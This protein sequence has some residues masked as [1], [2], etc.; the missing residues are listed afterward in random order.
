MEPFIVVLGIA[1][2]LGL[3]VLI[4]LIATFN[5]FVRLRQHMKESWS[6]IDVELKRRHD[7]IPNLVE[8]V[9]GYAAHEREV[10]EK[11]ILL[12]NQAA[13]SHES[14]AA[15][16]GDESAL[17]A[18]L[19]RLFALAENYPVLKADQNFLALQRE[20][21]LTE[22]RIAAARRFF[23]ANVRDNNR[24]C[25][26]FPTNILAGMFGF[27]PAEYFELSSAAERVV[28]RVELS[29]TQPG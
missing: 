10:L 23:N 8:T 24:L 26:E 7:L 9:R 3:I 20:L 6:D 4:W 28:P 12:R 22:D 11:I 2:G 13:G 1:A 5:R 19:P 15:L 27:T 18:A 16:A 25:A 29:R 14:R 21:S 17:M